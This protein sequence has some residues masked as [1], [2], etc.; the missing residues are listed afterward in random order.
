MHVFATEGCYF[1]VRDLPGEMCSARPFGSS[2]VKL[3]KA[4][5]RQR[6]TEIPLLQPGKVDLSLESVSA[7]RSFYYYV[8]GLSAALLEALAV[9]NPLSAKGRLLL[10]LP[11]QFAG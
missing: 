2:L 11:A 1:E 5:H 8:N 9:G 3:Q 6:E 4:G 10:C 7:G